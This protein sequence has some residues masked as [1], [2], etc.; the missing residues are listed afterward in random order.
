MGISFEC[1]RCG[2]KYKM[3]ATAQGKRFRCKECKTPLQVPLAM[4]TDATANDEAW[5]SKTGHP[6]SKNPKK[7]SK[8]DELGIFAIG[9]GIITGA[10]ELWLS[11]ATPRA[12]GVDRSVGVSLLGSA[13]YVVLGILTYFINGSS[14][15]I[16][17]TVALVVVGFLASLLI[18][19]SVVNAIVSV[20]VVLLVV[21]TGYDA[22][23]EVRSTHNNT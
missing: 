17:T 20:V 16:V 22:L 2:K 8:V 4:R 21:K 7:R 11:Y 13:V 19:F 14:A 9:L 3:N 15:I 18:N 6:E 10:L 5:R 1:D 23:K 12:G